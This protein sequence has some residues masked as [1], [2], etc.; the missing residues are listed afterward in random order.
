MS[1]SRLLRIFWDIDFRNRHDGLKEIMKKEGVDWKKIKPGDLV[2]FV[3]TARD[4]VIVLAPVDEEDTHGV[5][6]YYRSPHGR[7][8]EYAFQHIPEAFGGGRL[9]MKGA[10]KKAVMQKVPKKYHPVAKAANENRAALN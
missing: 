7:I 10:I 1:N 6:G 2:A 5:M 3:N 8:D 9:D 4:R